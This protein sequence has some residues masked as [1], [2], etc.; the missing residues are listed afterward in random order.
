MMKKILIVDDE[1]ELV[2]A[3]QIRLKRAG[4]RVLTAYDGGEG[5]KLAKKR[6][7]LILL[8][9]MMPTLSGIEVCQ[10]LK[11]DPKLKNIPII[12]LTAKDTKEDRIKGLSVG[13][14][15]YIV[16]PFYS[17]DLLNKIKKAL[18]RKQHG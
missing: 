7:D 17:D 15:E 4:Y 10:L 2:K 12:F 16:K 13:A 1:P 9:I 3:L 6:P 14:D 18:E 5:L 8:D 11:E